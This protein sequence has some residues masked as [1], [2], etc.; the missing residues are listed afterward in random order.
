MARSSSSSG[1]GGQPGNCEAAAT[2]GKPKKI[3][4]RYIEP[5]ANG[6]PPQSLPVRVRVAGVMALSSQHDHITRLCFQ[7]ALVFMHSECSTRT[8]QRPTLAPAPA[9]VTAQH[10]PGPVR[11]LRSLR[12]VSAVEGSSNA[13]RNRRPVLKFWGPTARYSQ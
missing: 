13:Q 12:H 2:Q 7:R 5:K 4:A 1:E 11:A 9:L 10:T 6:Q 3:N 8:A